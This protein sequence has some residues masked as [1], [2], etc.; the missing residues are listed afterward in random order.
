MRTFLIFRCW[1]LATLLIFAPLSQAVPTILVFGDSLSAGYGLRQ[2]AAW[3]VLLGKRL[4]DM[5][6]HYTVVNASI[7]GET[8][9]GGVTRIEPLL[10]KH[11]PQV[12]IVALGAND[13]LRGLPVDALR[14]NLTTII[15]SAQQRKARVLLL[16]QRIPPNYGPYAEQFRAVFGEVAKARK[17]ALVD[18]MLAGIATDSRYFQS[19]N[20]HPTAEAQKVILDTLW[21]ALAPLLK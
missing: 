2:D 19:D 6:Y 5:Q 8:S 9:R 18:F 7:S 21:P 20:L 17:T 12:V 14:D 4:Q 10:L 11:Q 13:G 1:L 3:P 16:G 15:R